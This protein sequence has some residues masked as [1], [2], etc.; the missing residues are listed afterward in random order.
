MKSCVD[1]PD[2]NSCTE[3]CSAVE[4]YVNQDEVKQKERIP[5]KN[6]VSIIYKEYPNFVWPSATKPTKKIIYL[7]RFQDKLSITEI[8]MKLDISHQYVSKVIN[9]ILK[10]SGIK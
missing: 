4:E 2:R 7:M 6:D 3:I 5:D 8:A 10:K 1:C 9:Q